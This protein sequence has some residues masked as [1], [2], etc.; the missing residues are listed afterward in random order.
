MRYVALVLGMFMIAWDGLYLGVVWK[1]FAWKGPF[2]RK[3]R[4]K[5]LVIA[6]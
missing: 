6:S 3:I 2:W 5:V 4:N 1:G